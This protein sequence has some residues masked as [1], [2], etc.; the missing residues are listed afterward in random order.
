M[1]PA[2]ALEIP[3]GTLGRVCDLVAACEGHLALSDQLQRQVFPLP[4]LI[5]LNY[6]GKACVESRPTKSRRAPEPAASGHALS[7]GGDLR[8]VS[9]TYRNSRDERR[10]LTGPTDS[11]IQLPIKI[12]WAAFI[13][14]QVIGLHLIPINQSLNSLFLKHSRYVPLRLR[15]PL[16]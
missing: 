15:K 1:V 7:R 12:A 2:G 5:I 6:L 9:F 11:S 8:L 3:R 14:L 10:Y 13:K 4:L 16:Y